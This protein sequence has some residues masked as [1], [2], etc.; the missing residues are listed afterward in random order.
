MKI[1]QKIILFIIS[2]LTLIAVSGGVSLYISRFLSDETAA[3]ILVHSKVNEATAN[4]TIL[5]LTLRRYE[6]DFFLNATD[7]EKQKE[8]KE[9]WKTTLLQTNK[10]LTSLKSNVSAFHISEDDKKIQACIDNLDVYEKGFIM[11]TEQFEKNLLRTPFEGNTAI[12]KY[13]G[14]IRDFETITKDLSSKYSEKL[15]KKKEDL[16]DLQKT[17]IF[18]L[19]SVNLITII[20]SVSI[21]VLIYRSVVKPI[22]L[23]TEK[24][25][26]ISE[27]DGDLT[28]Q[29]QIDTQDETR[30]LAQKINLFIVKI[31]TLITDVI[32]S[33]NTLSDSSEKISRSMSAHVE[34][35]NTTGE[36]IQSV[37]KSV[38]DL[39]GI[40]ATINQHNSRQTENIHKLGEKIDTLVVNANSIFKSITKTKKNTE[41]IAEKAKTSE[42]NMMTMNKN[43]EEISNS[44]LKM[45]GILEII[46]SISN[47]INLLSLNAAI[48]AARAGEAG[49]GFSVVASEVTSLADQ[50][51][52]SIKNIETL[53]HVNRE[54]IQRGISTVETTMVSMKEIISGIQFINSSVREIESILS[55]QLA[56]NMEINSDTNEILK[57][58][59]LIN[60]GIQ[61]HN[62]SIK[63]VSSTFDSINSAFQSISK[64]CV[65]LNASAKEISK[66]SEQLKDKTDHF[67]V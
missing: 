14:P 34:D 26:N 13:K 11:I 52:K 57:N 61:S 24:V 5:S 8:Y 60:T 39:S 58:T 28:V 40:L 27:K 59:E 1:K 66:I 25:S 41:S 7:R 21:C 23:I 36:S 6:K 4:L 44:S 55:S 10:L 37:N 48:E 47:K 19:V 22:K 20:V 16:S 29:I 9:K 31:R 2:F 18:W 46:K 3:I 15:N 32:G 35:M 30:D 43:I 67:K 49:R 45:V 38:N 63:Q 56:S 42:S 65:S 33:A 12:S 51:N 62:N 53:I 17:A 54:E 50:T 64:K